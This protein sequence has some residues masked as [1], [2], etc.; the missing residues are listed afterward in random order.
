MTVSYTIN[1]S[2]YLTHQ[3]YN[4]SRSERIKKKRQRSRIFVLVIYLILAAF[5]YYKNK[6][7]LTVTFGVLAVGMYFYYP[8][9]ERRRYRKHYEAFIREHFKEGVDRNVTLELTQDYLLG[10][11][12]DNESKI[13]TKEIKRIA[14][15]QEVFLLQLTQGQ[16][17]IVPKRDI[18]N[19][20]ALRHMLQDIAAHVKAPYLEELH[21]KW[22]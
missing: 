14:E 12:G 13:K 21:W 18:A 2:D 10:T 11:E 7:G 6:L 3:L 8:V 4:A 1:E 20:D 9:I 19:I 22:S 15:L 5:F 17:L 16:T